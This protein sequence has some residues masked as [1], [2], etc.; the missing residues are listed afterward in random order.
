MSLKAHLNVSNKTQTVSFQCVS[1]QPAIS[2]SKHR[3][4]NAAQNVDERSSFLSSQV[5][6]RT[7]QS[8]RLLTNIKTRW[9]TYC[10]PSESTNGCS[11]KCQHASHPAPDSSQRKNGGKITGASNPCGNFIISWQIDKNTGERLKQWIKQHSMFNSRDHR[12]QSSGSAMRRAAHAHTY[13]KQVR[14]YT[15]THLNLPW[16]PQCC[17]ATCSWQQSNW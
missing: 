4:K 6:T 8:N 12:L 11:S 10:T 15:H 5:P 1:S 2:W 7:Q 17:M 14:G 3:S 13:V 9:L 16:M